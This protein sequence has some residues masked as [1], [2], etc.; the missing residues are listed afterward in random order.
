MNAGDS[1]IQLVLAVVLCRVIL[2]GTSC[3]LHEGTETR[4]AVVRMDEL[5]TDRRAVA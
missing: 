2:H 3:F 4:E 1:V 5:S